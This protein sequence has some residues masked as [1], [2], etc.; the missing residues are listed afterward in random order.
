MARSQL[1][2]GEEVNCEDSPHRLHAMSSM[3]D[4]HLGKC[5]KQKDN[6]TRSREKGQSL[7]S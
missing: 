3:W 7:Q 1:E 6:R 5:R 2:L 4:R